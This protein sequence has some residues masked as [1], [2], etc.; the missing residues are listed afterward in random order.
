MYIVLSAKRNQYPQIV[1]VSNYIL[2]NKS[3]RIFRKNVARRFKK[4]G[5]Y[6]EVLL[7]VSHYR[8][9][10]LIVEPD[11]SGVVSIENGPILQVAYRSLRGYFLNYKRYHSHAKLFA[12]CYRI[13]N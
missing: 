11:C 6:A 4:G 7:C 5:L 9:R 3:K 1:I 8:D 10:E 12:V 13:T 2:A